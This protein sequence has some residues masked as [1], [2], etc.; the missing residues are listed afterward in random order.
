MNKEELVKLLSCPGFCCFGVSC[1]RERLNENPSDEIIEYNGHNW[2]LV[3]KIPWQGPASIVSC[4]ASA[5]PAYIAMLNA[6]NTAIRK[7][8]NATSIWY[9][10]SLKQL[11]IALEKISEA[12]DIVSAVGF[13]LEILRP[14][15]DEH[16]Y[17]AIGEIQRLKGI[18]ENETG[19]QEED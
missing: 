11:D 6:V 9:P 3:V 10:H 13:H 4:A 1:H 16:L 17:D 15:A 5:D 7:F 18:I 14:K 8:H 19:Y 12:R 2:K